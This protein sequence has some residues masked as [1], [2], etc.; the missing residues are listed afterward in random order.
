MPVKVNTV[1]CAGKGFVTPNSHDELPHSFLST[2]DN[3]NLSTM[4]FS[5]LCIFYAL[6]P[7]ACLFIDRTLNSYE[8]LFY[9]TLL[10][11]TSVHYRQFGYGIFSRAGQNYLEN[12]RT[13]R[14][15]INE[16]THLFQIKK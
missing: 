5:S 3:S 16:Y 7:S 6:F 11:G 10:L 9:Y 14:F 1:T 2:T 4:L 15:K 13:L 8:I 12:L